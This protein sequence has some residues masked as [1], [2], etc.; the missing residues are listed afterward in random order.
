[1]RPTLWLYPVQNIDTAL[2]FFCGVLGLQLKFRDADRYAAI[3]SGGLRL[4]LVAGS[5]RIAEQPLPV[6]RAE[7]MAPELQRL[8]TAGARIVRPLERGP[9][10][11]RVILQSTDGIALMLTAALDEA[12]PSGEPT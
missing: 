12:A 7:S 5:E 11:Q 4:G 2:A 8:L 6:F 9:H 10:E 1:M 3:E